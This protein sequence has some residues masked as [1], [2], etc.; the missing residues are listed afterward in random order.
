MNK[1]KVQNGIII[2]GVLHEPTYNSDDT[3]EDCSLFWLCYSDD[4]S[5][6]FCSG[7]FDCGKIIRK[8]VN[9]EGL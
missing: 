6:A 4:M 1:M 7:I 8:E 3:C 5:N 9:F 2:D